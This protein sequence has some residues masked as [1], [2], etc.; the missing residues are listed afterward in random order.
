M[1]G[2][3]TGLRR[4][5][6]L[7]VLC[8]QVASAVAGVLPW[9][10]LAVAAPLLVLAAAASARADEAQARLLRLVSTGLALVGVVLVLPRATSAGDARE[11]LGPLLVGVSVLQA[12]VWRTR[13]DLQGGLSTGLGLLVLGASF[14]PDVLVGLPLLVGWAAALAAG[15]LAG[16][17]RQVALADVVLS[18]GAA[19][20]GADPGAT[21]GRERRV[22]VLPV[23]LAAVLGLAAFL[24]VPVTQ[25]AGL[26][27]RL[28]RTAEAAGASSTRGALGAGI[29]TSGRVDLSVRGDLGE[30]PLLEV[31]GDSPALWRGAVYDTWDGRAWTARGGGGL[32]EVTGPPYVVEQVVPTRVDDV[33]LLSSSDGTVLAPGRPV[34]LERGA[35]G[36]ARTVDGA[37]VAR[38]LDDYRVA[39][40]QLPAPAPLRDGPDETDPRWTQLPADL[41]LRVRLLAGALTSGRDRPT[42][43]AAV[44]DWLRAN[45]TY[46]TDSPVPERG[47]DAVDRFLFVDRTGFCEQFAAAGTVLLRAAGIPARFVSGVAYGVPVDDGRRTYREKD[48]HTWVEVFHPGVGWVASDPTAGAV[49]ADVGAGS[50]RARLV[51]PL[52]GALRTADALPGGRPALAV[53]LL[54]ATAVALVPRR[55]RRGASLAVAG[56]PALQAFSRWDEQLGVQRRR[57]HESL[58]ELAVRLP[59]DERQTAALGVVEQECYAPTAPETQEAVRILRGGAS[60]RS[61]ASRASDDGRSRR[62]W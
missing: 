4:A 62:P 17:A 24:L 21:R 35:A 56:G 37:V 11:V 43:V 18:G 32:T 3:M 42:A 34:A 12:A 40:V 50:L 46:R 23:A 30:S 22:V 5:V 58:R 60:G 61:G 19:P 29:F 51:A 38:G 44:E 7:T 1:T 45:A 14:A 25:D 15:V 49:R 59:L 2:A 33:R 20:G 28:A 52:T 48:L 41:P 13:R 53:A 6:L 57:D 8:G 27:S 36:V 47:Q 39:S 9:V 26:Q 54:A 55:R 31:P 10:G 16:R